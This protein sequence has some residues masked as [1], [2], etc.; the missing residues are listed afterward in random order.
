MSSMRHTQ[1]S[2]FLCYSLI[3]WLF[4][5]SYECIAILLVFVVYVIHF[6]SF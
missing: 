6:F 3:V 5:N 1:I 4:Y 2:M